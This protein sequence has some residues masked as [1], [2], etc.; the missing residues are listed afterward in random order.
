MLIMCNAYFLLDRHEECLETARSAERIF[1]DDGD[2]N[3]Q[4]NALNS[5]IQC[6]CVLEQF[7]KALAASKKGRNCFRE[8]GNRNEEVTMALAGVNA[9]IMSSTAGKKGAGRKQWDECLKAAKEALKMA[10]GVDNTGAIGSALFMVAHIHVANERL[11]E[12]IKVALE[13]VQVNKE[14]GNQRA[15]A[16]SQ[17]LLCRAYGSTAKWQDCYDVAQ[18][19]LGLCKAIDDDSMENIV[20]EYIDLVEQQMQWGKYSPQRMQMQMPQGGGG[21]GGGGGVPVW[22]QQGGAMPMD[23]GGGAASGTVQRTRGEAITV[24]GLDLNVIADKVKT[25]SA[26]LMGFDDVAELEVDAPFMES[27]LTSSSSVLLR[28]EI[29]AEMPG[30]N[31]P[32]TLVFDYPT[33]QAVAE[34]IQEK[35]G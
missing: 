4:G 17:I 15:E 33:V 2:L 28:D 10:R 8:I 5:Q 20:L 31:L 11:D 34:Y 23:M 1:E 21:G 30:V 35:A 7:D 6:M 22:Q 16:S 29:M 25:I 26:Q 13:A 9:L 14:A 24:A 12:G 19:A 32:F 27:G 18:Q 3:G